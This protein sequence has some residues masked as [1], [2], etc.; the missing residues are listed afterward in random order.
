MY[1][2]QKKNKSGVIS[3]QVIDKSSGKYKVK[4]TIGSSADPDEIDRLVSQARQW[5]E[6]YTGELK[7]DFEGLKS[8]AESFLDNI[9]EIN[10]CGSA[11]L[12][13]KLFDEIGFNKIASPLFKPLVLA[14]I[15][16]PVSKL[17]T[18]DYWYKYYNS[19]V[20][21]SSI[22]RYMDKLHK[23]EREHIQQISFEHTQRILGAA[24]QMV[25]YDVTTIYFETD[26]EDELRKTGFSKEGKH[27]HPQIVLGLL[28]STGGYPLAYDIF[29]GN[30]YEGATMLPVIDAFKEK[31]GFKQVT[32]VADSGLINA[33]NIQQLDNKGYS[34]IL[35]ARLKSQP[36]SIKE[37]VLSLQLIDGQS[38][39]IKKDENTTLVVHYSAKRAK[40]DLH[41]RQRGLRR[42]Q[43]AMKSRKLTKSSINNRGYNK[44]LKLKGELEVEIDMEKYA[45]DAKWDGL[46]GYQTNT[47][48]AA[49]D[50]IENYG[51]LWK[52][53]KAFRI[54][55]TDLKIRP[56]FHRLERRIESHICLSFVAY[57]V[58]KELERQLDEKQV[59]MSPEKAI[60]IA[61]T[62]YKVRVKVSL[63]QYIDKVVLLKEEQRFLMNI[64]GLN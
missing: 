8:R 38:A 59:D 7:L 57:K 41:N 46:K 4:Q 20:D 53:E 44:Y 23:L 52:I 5:I 14:R 64:F 43:E 18:T 49:R 54:S 11:L 39:T 21:I 25:F 36:A 62:I 55:K 40:K 15:E 22:Y 9:S 60:D 26:Q 58:Y 12:L 37:K 48:L 3:V 50:I 45:M 2:R 6:E 32:I 16:N 1:V 31:Y 51:Q 13:G 35:G 30:Q 10:I 29:K 42:L 34:Y 47:K 19:D 24:I 63:N 33:S 61:K 28:V 17:R 27:Q 56:I